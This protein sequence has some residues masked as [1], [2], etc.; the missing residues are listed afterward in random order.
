MMI[1]RLSRRAPR[2]W[3][4]QP[5]IAT[6]VLPALLWG[7][8]T[9]AQTATPAATAGASRTPPGGPADARA[10]LDKYCVTC[11]N[12]RLHTANLILQQADTGT[13]GTEAELWEKVL[14]KV[15]T[16][17]MPPAG[18]ARPD[19]PTSTAFVTWLDA[20]LARAAAANPRPGRP[21]IHRLN[22]AEYG[23]AIR[24]LLA[25]EVDSRALLPVDDSG[26]GF[27]NIGD[28]LSV[29]PGL[30]ERYMTAARRISRMAV[31]DPDLKPSFQTYSAP[32]Y[33][34][35]DDRVDERLSFGSRGGI[36]IPHYFPLDGKY[37]LKIKLQ[38]TWRDEVRGLG[39]RHTLDVRLDRTRIKTFTIGGD[40][41]R[42]TW[43]PGQAVPNPTE[44]ELNADAGLEVTFSAKAGQHIVGLGFVKQTVEEEGFLRPNLPVTSF[45][46]AGNRE[47]EPAVDTVQIGGPYEAQG[48]GDTPSRRRIFVCRPGAQLG[49]TACARRIL[50]TLARRAY[51]RPVTADDVDRLMA[52]YKEGRARGQFDSGVEFALRRI[53]TSPEFLFRIERD[54]AGVAPAASYRITDVE[55]ASRLSFFLWSSIP[56]DELLEA[57]EKGQLKTAA[58][59]QQQVKRMLAD[60]RASALV[61]NFAGQ[62]LYL[63]NVRNHAPDPA[64]FP[65]FEDNL[66]QAFQQETDLFLQSNLKDDR[67]VVDLLTADFTFVNERL[68]RHYGISGVYGSHFRRVTLTDPRR[69]GLLGQGSVLTVTSY[70][71]RTSPVLRGKWLLENILGTPPPP[72]PPNVPALSDTGA[73]GKPTSVRERMEQHRKNPVCASCHSRMDPL[74]F[75]LE[76]FDAIGRWRATDDGNTAVDPSGALPDG[77]RFQG[78]EGLRRVLLSRREQFVE[79]VTEKLMIYA[80]GRG[81]EPYDL[82]VVRQVSREA[83][84]DNLRWSA[85]VTGIVTSI[86]FQ[87]RLAAD[88]PVAP[89]RQKAQQP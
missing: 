79:T 18:A 11:H 32:K 8:A 81:L 71:T 49:E 23:N 4:W 73:G 69:F 12:E 27:D 41:A 33:L 24:D 66:R 86:P 35:Q 15:A 3:V 2:R 67:S 55:L 5:A 21:T 65:D 36:A 62:W 85:I 88:A 53:L 13:V 61:S 14:R 59:V 48:A 31:G 77:T 74:G 72:P 75:A 56:D 37:T 39:R 46:Y 47:V 89:D 38:R 64:A 9:Q 43:L 20:E 25:V 68:A 1:I 42:S 45:E 84:A 70:P 30:F 28:V 50:G 44:Y 51:R 34:V 29:S 63:R 60:P 6:M 57:A 54:P 82:P 83:A 40:G 16:G 76:N 78:P 52:F 26:Y 58:G 87:M 80:L 10:L 19:A 7:T 17:S 22:R